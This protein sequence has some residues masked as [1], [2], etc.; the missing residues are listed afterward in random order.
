MRFVHLLEPLRQPSFLESP[1]YLPLFATK[2]GS[3]SHPTVL[4][5]F[6]MSLHYHTRPSYTRSRSPTYITR[7][8]SPQLARGGRLPPARR[9]M[10]GIGVRSGLC[11]HR[12]DEQLRGDHRRANVYTATPLFPEWLRAVPSYNLSV[13]SPEHPPSLL[14]V[15]SVWR[16]GRVWTGSR[17]VT[18]A[19]LKVKSKSVCC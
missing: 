10:P 5:I 18:D 14:D 4:Y 19:C 7:T 1:I 9:S 6:A 17:T 11:R 16:S 2:Q 12:R 13:L 8:P 3:R 15:I